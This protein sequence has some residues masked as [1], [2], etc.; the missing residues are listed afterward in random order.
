MK[1]LTRK[2]LRALITNPL[3]VLSNSKMATSYSPCALEKSTYDWW[4]ALEILIRGLYVISFGQFQHGGHLQCM[5][6]RKINLWLI[7]WLEILTRWILRPLTM[8]LLHNYQN[9]KLVVHPPHVH[10]KT[11]I[12]HHNSL[13]IK[14]IIHSGQVH[15]KNEC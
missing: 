1:I 5:R 2:F 15:F 8:N 3:S 13:N 10:E 6:A 12:I 7:K 4:N 11:N 9:T 14:M